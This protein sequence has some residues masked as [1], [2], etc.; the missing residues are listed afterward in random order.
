MLAMKM[1]L[2]RNSCQIVISNKKLFYVSSCVYHKVLC[3]KFNILQRICTNAC[4]HTFAEIDH[5]IISTA[6]LLPS[7]CCQLQAKAYGRS[8]G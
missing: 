5:E 8:T 4:A 3:Y 7:G 6:I 1:K 2:S